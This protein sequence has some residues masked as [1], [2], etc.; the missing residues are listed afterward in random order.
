MIQNRELWR[1]LKINSFLA[2]YLHHCGPHL[3]PFWRAISIKKLKNAIPKTMEKNNNEKTRTF[4]PKGCQNEA[5]INAK[6][7]QKSMYKLVAEK[8]REIMKK[9]VFL[10]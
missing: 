1:L 8:T 3:E 6:T 10:K 9:H 2:P 4:A 5:K 7:H